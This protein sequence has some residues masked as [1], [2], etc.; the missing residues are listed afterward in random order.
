MKKILILGAG[1]AGTMVA[2]RLY[3]LLDMEEWQITLVDPDPVHYYQPGFL[4][5]PFGMYTKKDV[6]KP[7]QNFIPPHVRLI[8]GA[9]EIIEPDHNQ[10]RLVDGTLLPYDFL[11]V[12]TG[13]DI[14]PEETPGL[15]EDEWGKS[16]HTFYSLQGA[17]RIVAMAF[18]EPRSW[19]RVLSS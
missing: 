8:Q 12:A 10:A 3:K 11:I 18:C 14:H 16:I 2:N 13:A 17:S 5:M 9:V 19:T 4:L 7:K 1:T 15:G 6:V